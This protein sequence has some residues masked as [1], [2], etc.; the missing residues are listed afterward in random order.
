MFSASDLLH[1]SR[2]GLAWESRKVE[3]DAAF[4]VNLRVLPCVAAEFEWLKIVPNKGP[5][6]N[7][8][9]RG[10]DKGVGEA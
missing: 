6:S 5:G 9:F 7:S 3:V 1:R 2:E 4:G 8:V 10:A